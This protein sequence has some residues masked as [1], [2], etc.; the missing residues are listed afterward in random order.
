MKKVLKKIIDILFIII[1]IVLAGYFVLRLTGKI[2][3]YQVKTGS[4]IPAIQVND[5]IMISQTNEYKKGDIVTFKYENTL[6]THRIVEINDNKVITKG[7]ANNTNDDEIDIES[8][9]G[10]VI[11]IGGLLNII[12]NYKFVIIGLMIIIYIVSCFLEKEDKPVKEE[13]NEEEKL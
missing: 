11:F 3:L 2:D 4:M 7:D 13:N 6:V 5:Y 1:I 12:V 9:T 8:I 10:K